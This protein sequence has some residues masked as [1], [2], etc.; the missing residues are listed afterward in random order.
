VH[1]SLETARYVVTIAVREGM[2]QL[3]GPDAPELEH[4]RSTPMP[5]GLLLKRL[6]MAGINLVPTDTDAEFAKFANGQVRAQ[7]WC[8]D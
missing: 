7:T 3:V 6:S 2:C 4:I 8:G 5:P 1:V